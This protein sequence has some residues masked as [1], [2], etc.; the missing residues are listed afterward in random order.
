MKKIII[1]AMAVLLLLILA[2]CGE[3]VT[4]VAYTRFEATGEQYVYY[5]SVMA[6]DQITV[7]E[8][9]AACENKE[10]AD[11]TFDF[12]RCLGRDELNEVPYILVDVSYDE[13]SM[14]VIVI[15][16]SPMYG[17]SKAFYLNGTKLVPTKVIDEDEYNFVMFCYRDVNFV[18]T[19]PHGH[20]DANKVNVIEYK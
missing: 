19:N 15:K 16:D 3:T 20:I 17:S 13:V 2:S 8:N 7:Y 1:G 12:I 11:I 4:P 5:S 6:L 14:D 18:R 9:K 10:G